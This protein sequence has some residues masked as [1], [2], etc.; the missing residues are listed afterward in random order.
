MS[1][2]T[3]RLQPD[4][5][6]GLETLSNRLQRSKNRLVNEGIREFVARQEQEQAHGRNV[7][8]A[9]E[10]DTIRDFVFG[11]YV[12]RYVVHGDALVVLRPWHQ[13]ETRDGD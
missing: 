2:T 7:P 8:Q 9:P 5:E 10:P 1:I 12:V 3:V 11:K 13:H 6:S 4:V